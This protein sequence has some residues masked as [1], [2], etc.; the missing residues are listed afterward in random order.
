M[1]KM[2]NWVLAAAAGTALLL[3]VPSSAKGQVAF[4]GTFGGPHGQFSIGVGSPAFPAGAYVPYPYVRHVYVRPGYGYGFY[5][6]NAWVPVQP[7]GTRY[8]VVERPVVYYNRPY[9]RR[10]WD[11]R[12]WR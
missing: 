2:K 4:Q 12:Y 6:G 3:S 10:H 8:I 11:H 9:Y 7:Y 5:Y 1:R